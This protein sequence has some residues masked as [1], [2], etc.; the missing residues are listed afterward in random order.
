MMRI[1]NLAPS[2]TVYDAKTAGPA[3][4]SALPGRSDLDSELMSRVTH[5]A[6]REAFNQ[7]AMHYAPRLKAWL[8]HRGE[9]DA[10]AEDI[11]QDVMVSVWQKAASFDRSK[12]TFSTWVYRLTRNRWIDHKRK[13]D[14][15]QPVAP[16][17]MALLADDIVASP[18]EEFEQSE[19]AIAV[20][21]A[22][23]TLPPEQKQ[24]LYLAFFEGLS[25]SAIAARTGIPIGTVKSRIRAPLAKLRGS[26]AAHW[27]DTP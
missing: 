1:P 13:H 16:E 20:R 2:G 14:R 6:D 24:M 12:A 7:L 4:V 23:A 5:S 26:L 3:T 19:S 27:K 10:T 21:E 15:V 25:H 17:D 9:G 18:H 22:M 11:V 8:M